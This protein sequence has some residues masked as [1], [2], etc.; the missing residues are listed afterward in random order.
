VRSVE[1][2]RFASGACLR[3]VSTSSFLIELMMK[4][5]MKRPNLASSLAY[6]DLPG[7]GEAGSIRLSNLAAKNEYTIEGC[8]TYCRPVER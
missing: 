7:E 4:S 3:R 5:R 1:I 6:E 2:S 8:V